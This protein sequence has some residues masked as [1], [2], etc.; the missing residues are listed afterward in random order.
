MHFLLNRP[1]NIGD[2]ILTLPLAA[3]LKEHF[4]DCKISMLARN[5]AKDVVDMAVD[6]DQFVSADEFFALDDSAAVEYLKQLHIDVFLPVH[7]H[8]RLCHLM[9]KARVPLR[10]GHL[11]R[12]YYF[13]WANKIIYIKRKRCDLHQAQMCMQY[14]K[15]FNLPFFVPVNEIAPLIRLKQPVSSPKVKKYL[16]PKAFNLVIHP[17]TNG[18]TIEW[19]KAHFA[20]L[21]EIMPKQ[22]KIFITGSAKEAEKYGDLVQCRENVIPLFGAF[23]VTEL[24]SFLKQVDG[25]IVGSTGPL[26]L[27]AALGTKVLGLFPA[28]QDLNVKRWGP[29]GANASTLEAPHCAVSTGKDPKRCDC[30]KCI[31]PE[32]VLEFIQKNWL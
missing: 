14:L 13:F 32:Q 11:N 19:P 28:Q 16:D 5:Y 3:K 18:H 1:D 4:P 23:S 29:I 12:F 24:A 7:P 10:V 25:V 17:G 15:A 22:V 8:K 31:T 6:I 21:I 27:S 26:H 9:K 2:V 30:M 20:K